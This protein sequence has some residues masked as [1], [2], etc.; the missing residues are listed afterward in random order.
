MSDR[1][2]VRKLL[3][4]HI[5]PLS[6]NTVVFLSEDE[7][8]TVNDIEVGWSVTCHYPSTYKRKK[9]NVEK[10]EKLFK[11]KGCRTR[12]YNEKIKN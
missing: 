9:F 3:N 2:L 1:E 8:E 4:R 10:L 11:E 6:N 12:R 5:V 7:I